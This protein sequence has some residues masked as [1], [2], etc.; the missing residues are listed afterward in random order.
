MWKKFYTNSGLI[1]LAVLCAGVWFRN[2]RSFYP[3]KSNDFAYSDELLASSPTPAP[4]LEEVLKQEW[5]KLASED[6]LRRV[7]AN[8]TAIRRDGSYS[9][10]TNRQG[11]CSQHCGVAQWLSR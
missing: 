4:S 2:L 5:F 8:A 1:L 9:H 11:A 10:A 6:V 3:P 7:R